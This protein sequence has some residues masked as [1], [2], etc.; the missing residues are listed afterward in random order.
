MP[1]FRT[2]AQIFAHLGEE[3]WSPDW[4]NYNTVQ[5]PPTKPWDYQ[6]DMTI[7]DVEIW[8]VIQEGGNGMGI[9][10]SWLPFA[11][12]YMVMIN[13][14]MAF[15][16]GKGAQREMLKFIKERGVKDLPMYSVL[17]TDEDYKYFVDSDF[18]S[19]I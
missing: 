9:Y 16:Y 12:F 13:W 2:T 14:D 10:A 15:F 8:E 1:V 5:L 11:E 3:V 17:V 4:S 6:R 18:K 19:N 7:E